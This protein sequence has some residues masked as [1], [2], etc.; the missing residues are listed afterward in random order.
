MGTPW[1]DV[2]AWA[3]ALPGTREVFVGSWGEWT[4]RC[5]EKIFAI[6]GPEAAT[7]S[8]KA[9]MQDQAELVGS[10]P[11][12]YSVAPYVGRFGWVRV[13]LATADADELRQVVIEAWR[14]TAPKRLIREYDSAQR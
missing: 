11:D 3:L 13:A 1:A 8:V 5:G 4:L 7:L 2:R 12:I 6:G 14:R 9:S 10:A